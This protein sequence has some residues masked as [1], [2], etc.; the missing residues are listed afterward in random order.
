MPMENDK[1]SETE[2]DLDHGIN[3]V[4]SSPRDALGF[5]FGRAGS[6]DPERGTSSIPSA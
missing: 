1:P 4:L 5:G 6:F 2:R 3:S